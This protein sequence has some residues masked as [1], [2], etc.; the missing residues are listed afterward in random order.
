MTSLQVKFVTDAQT[1]VKQYAHDLLMQG[2]KNLQKPSQ[3]T[4]NPLPN[5]DDFMKSRK[6]KPSQKIAGKWRK[7]L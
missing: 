7:Y 1:T 5:N 2:H 4:L 3:L 6:K